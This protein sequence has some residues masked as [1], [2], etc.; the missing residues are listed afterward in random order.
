MWIFC[1][2]GPL[3]PGFLKCE[4]FIIHLGQVAGILKL[5]WS[6]GHLM[7]FGP[8]LPPKILSATIQLMFC[9]ALGTR[10]SFRCCCNCIN[11]D[12]LSLAKLQNEVSKLLKTRILFREPWVRATPIGWCLWS[13]YFK[14]FY[15]LFIALPFI[16]WVLL[17]SVLRSMVKDFTNRKCVFDT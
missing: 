4:G 2:I 3:N 10:F 12:Q 6:K 15:F 8:C 5:Q 14:L 17:T 1:K 13:F 9:P 16:L 7:L 11:F